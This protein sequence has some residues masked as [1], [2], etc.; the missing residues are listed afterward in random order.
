MPPKRNFISENRKKLKELQRQISVTK[1]LATTKVNK[2]LDNKKI[3]K[4]EK[5]IK[6]PQENTKHLPHGRSIS[7]CRSRSQQKI[8]PSKST[9]SR[10]L[11]RS[12]S[13]SSSKTGSA[14]SSSTTATKD[15]S[16]QTVDVNDELFLKD[17][18]IRLPSASVLRQLESDE[19]EIN[20]HNKV[21]DSTNE[22]NVISKDECDVQVVKPIKLLDDH[23][24]KRNA[25]IDKLTEFSRNHFISKTKKPMYLEGADQQSQTPNKSERR[26]R[27]F[28]ADGDGTTKSRDLIKQKTDEPEIVK[29]IN[30]PECKRY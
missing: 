12:V 15:S 3:A 14:C 8:E 4:N 20:E 19:P 24:L 6:L 30:V 29:K 11:S 18:I 16:S 17:V 7:T 1:P 13:S 10:R 25:Q 23:D 27:W 26:R 28:D 9:K 22:I 5:P 21:V 2:I